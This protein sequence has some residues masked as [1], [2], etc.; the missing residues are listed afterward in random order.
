MNKDIFMP[1]NPV[2]HFLTRIFDLLVLSVL[3]LV[4][5]IPVITIGAST[6]ALYTMTLKWMMGEELPVVKG[7]FRA[8]R[9]N[10]K[11]G[12]FMSLV[13]LLAMGL[14]FADFH[15]LG[16]G[17]MA[18]SSLM[19]GFCI[20]LLVGVLAVFGYAF[21]LMAKFENTV[22]QILNNAW[23]LAATHLPYTGVIVLIQ[24]IPFLWFLFLPSS[25]MMVFWVWLFFGTAGSAYFC[26][27][28]LAKVFMEL[29]HENENKLD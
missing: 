26:S 22:P 16:A 19:Y 5:S 29:I 14:L 28:F 15:L 3:W 17:T 27:F 23:R 6:A 18:G 24:S 12:I 25:F 8:F 11:Q 1:E 2:N 20:V 21:P 4:C 10:L 7:F 9:A 13:F